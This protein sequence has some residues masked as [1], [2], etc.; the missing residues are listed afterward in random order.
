[1]EIDSARDSHEPVLVEE[2]LFW[3][4]CKPGGVYVDCTLGYAGLAARLLDRTAPDGILVGIDRDAAALAESRMRLREVAHRVHF[5]HGNFC[6]L[7]ALIIGSGVSRVDGVIFDLGV[8]SPQL[9]RAERGFSFREDGPLDMRMDQREGRTAADLVRDLPETELADLIYQLG[10]ERY[11][12][13]IARAI[14]QA[15]MQGVIATTWQLAA[16]V[17]RAVPASYRHGRIHCATRTFQALRIAVNRELDVLEPAL[18]DAVDILA[19]GGRV[20]AV[21]FHSLED[22]I[23]KHTFRALA[24]GPE[25]SVRVLTKKP[26][27]ASENERNRNPRSRSAK[28]RVVERISKEYVK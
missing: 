3:L 24:N 22:R 4:Q 27:I 7:K 20:C 21:S 16:V 11:S 14:V 2:I 13:R 17:E 5:R 6:D 18:R 28:L 12:R 25:A 26:V 9:D 1:M 10:E 23:V 19:P 8:S 15:R